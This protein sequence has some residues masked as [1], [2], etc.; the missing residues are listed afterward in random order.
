M[1]VAAAAVKFRRL[2]RRFGVAAPRVTVRSY[3][4]WQWRAA[5]LAVTALIIVTV[6]WFLAQQGEEAELAREIQGLQE[7]L[8]RRD[9]ELSRL[10][11]GAAT[12]QNAVQMEKSA[13]QRLASRIKELE[14]ENAALK[15][16]VSLVQRLMGECSRKT[17]TGRRS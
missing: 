6:A 4:G 14:D 7:R 8:S 1:P 2:S 13:Q 16:E 3:F 15:E 17:G 11:V 12:G 9:E 10:R 5:G